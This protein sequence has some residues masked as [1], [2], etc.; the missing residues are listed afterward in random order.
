MTGKH[1][2]RENMYFRGFDRYYGLRDGTCN[3]FNPGERRPGEPEPAHKTWAKPRH[4]C[5]DEITYAPYTPEYADF[6]TTDY[7]TRNASLS[8]RHV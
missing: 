5:I 3:Y 4:W 1:H 6:Y 8:Q 7:F 2:G